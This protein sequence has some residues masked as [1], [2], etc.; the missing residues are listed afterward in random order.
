[1][2]VGEDGV[3]SVEVRKDIL[4]EKRGWDKGASAKV[5]FMR[6]RLARHGNR[7]LDLKFIGNYY[8]WWNCIRGFR[9]L[10]SEAGGRFK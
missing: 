1:M 2:A 7:L 6:K 9:T 5:G 3:K 4:L 8:L 10:A